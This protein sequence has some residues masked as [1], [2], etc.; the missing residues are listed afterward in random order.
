VPVV[1]RSEVKE[2]L[3]EVRNRRMMAVAR[4]VA[5]RVDSLGWWTV[6]HLSEGI[7]SAVR[8]HFYVRASK[9][10][11]SFAEQLL[12]DHRRGYPGL[13]AAQRN[14]TNSAV[15]AVLPLLDEVRAEQ[16]DLGE[17]G[18][19]RWLLDRAGVLGGCEGRFANLLL[20]LDDHVD[21][22]EGLGRFLGQVQPVGEDLRSGRPAQAV[23][24][25]TMTASKG[26]TV[27]AA[28]VVGVEEGI[29]P[30]PRADLAEE[31]RL[32]YVAMT[33]STEYLYLT[34][35]G[36]RTGPTARAGEARVARGRNRSPLL[37]HGPVRSEDGATYLDSIGA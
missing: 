34:W 13:A 11:I 23:R 18:W 1:N 37:T 19:G 31:R 7:G 8:D 16:A 5:N 26:L 3:A 29:I 4:L 21:P 14:R 30:R 33:R 9:A 20:E 2:M 12:E 22:S 35:A 10:N 32:L 25:M 28:I 17:G 6:L 15:D 36:R 24:L 27:R